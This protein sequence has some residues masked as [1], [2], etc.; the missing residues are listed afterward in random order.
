META[1][2]GRF[3]DAI[4]GD[5]GWDAQMIGASHLWKP[6]PPLYRAARNRVGI[7]LTSNKSA[8]RLSRGL[9]LV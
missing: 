8:E 3:E 9:L 7:T 6:Q 1:V 4:H 2:T 5:L